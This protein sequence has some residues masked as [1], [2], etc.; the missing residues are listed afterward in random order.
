M[1]RKVNFNVQQKLK[2]KTRD[3]NNK[4][5]EHS[6]VFLVFL[7]K[8]FMKKVPRRKKGIDFFYPYLSWRVNICCWYRVLTFP[9]YTK[10][11]N[12]SQ[13]ILHTECTH[14][15]FFFMFH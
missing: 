15:I 5:K 12:N 10:R 13:E 14:N 4:K 7:A 9:R 11:N 1:K 6:K 8:I 3:C 2:D